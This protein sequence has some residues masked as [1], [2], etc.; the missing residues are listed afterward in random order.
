[1]INFFV[2][3]GSIKDA[4]KKLVDTIIQDIMTCKQELK[5]KV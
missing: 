1:M 5:D 2:G 4:I 3:L